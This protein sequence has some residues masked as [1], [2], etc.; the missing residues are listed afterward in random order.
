MFYAAIRRARSAAIIYLGIL[1]AMAICAAIIVFISN[2]GHFKVIH[3]TTNV[4]TSGAQTTTNAH[5]GSAETT[6]NVNVGDGKTDVH[7]TTGAPRRGPRVHGT[8]RVDQDVYALIVGGM[9]YAL[10]FLA[11]AMG[12]TFAAENDG[13]LEFAWTRPVTRERYALGILAVDV[14]SMLVAFVLSIAIVILGL[15]ACGGIELLT[16]SHVAP[17]DF[18]SELLALGLPLLMYAWI[19]ALSASLRRGRA[20]VVLIWP[21]MF[22]L[23]IAAAQTAADSPFKPVLMALNRYL[24][25]L[26]IFSG[27]GHDLTVSWTAY[28][29]AFA[30]VLMALAIG[31]WRRLEA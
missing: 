11:T 21:A 9:A 23:A 20:F 8:V 2:G 12:L 14:A 15:L 26:E 29:L 1:A 4:H 19:A 31:Q 30:A 27:N 28:G 17:S 18:G 25:P 13:H 3:P 5:S 22:V 16:Q 7:Q 24:N 10:A 6:V